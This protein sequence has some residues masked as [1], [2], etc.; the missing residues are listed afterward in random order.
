MPYYGSHMPYY[1][2]P[3]SCETA[4][5]RMA[6]GRAWL[7]KGSPVARSPFVQRWRPAAQRG[8][9]AAASAAPLPP[10]LAPPLPCLLPLPL[11]PRSLARSLPRA[12]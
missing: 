8:S 4:A 3:R 5:R 10:P 6:G 12:R 7:G 9:S 2:S 1:G 11:P